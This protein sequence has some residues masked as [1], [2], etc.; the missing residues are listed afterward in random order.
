MQEMSPNLAKLHA[1]FLQ[2]S[3]GQFGRSSPNFLSA[4]ITFPLHTGP[5]RGWDY[6]Y[7]PP[8]PPPQ[9]GWAS[10]RWAR[11]LLL[12]VTW[13]YETQDSG[14]QEGD[15]LLFS[16]CLSQLLLVP[17]EE[18]EEEGWIKCLQQGRKLG[19]GKESSRET[20]KEDTDR[21]LTKQR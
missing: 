16:Q 9:N 15:R 10:F 19:I 21:S 12:L 7:A 5:T 18:E 17:V 11:L 6:T 3:H 4:L 8:S 13:A 20:G 1:M 2:L 14:S